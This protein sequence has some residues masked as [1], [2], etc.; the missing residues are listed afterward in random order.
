MHRKERHFLILQDAREKAVVT[1]PDLVKV[2][3]ASEATI[4]RDIIELDS[5]GKLK[6]IR[7][8]AES[9]SPTLQPRLK[10]KPF[11]I[12]EQIADWIEKRENRSRI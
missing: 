2:T 12:N 4:R 5:E 10:G 1:V 9:V 7:G 6:K 3:G 11:E 8:G